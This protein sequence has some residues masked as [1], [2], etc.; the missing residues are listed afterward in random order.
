MLGIGAL[1]RVLY[2]GDALTFLPRFPDM[3]FDAIITDPDYGVGVP[4]GGQKR[5]A[6]ACDAILAGMLAEATRLTNHVVCF[7]AASPERMRIFI[8]I[9]ERH[10]QIAHIG[11]WTKGQNSAPT[12]NGLARRWEP[13]FWLRKPKAKRNGEWRFS[14]DVIAASAIKRKDSLLVQPGQK[15]L[16]L[17]ERL[18]RFF[19]PVGGRVLDPFVGSGSTLVA[20]QNLGRSWVGC[21]IDEPIAQSALERLAAPACL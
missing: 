15:P 9:A 20:C 16:E 21:E 11:I 17:M 6:S 8:A 19:T 3:V 1:D 18:V 4:Y 2:V 10:W 7:W 12:G 14:P 13:W 5:S